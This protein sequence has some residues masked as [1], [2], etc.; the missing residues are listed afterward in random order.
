MSTRRRFAAIALAE[1]VAAGTAPRAL[2]AKV[3]QM[4]G[5]K[6]YDIDL[7]D[8]EPLVVYIETQDI[9]PIAQYARVR[10]FLQTADRGW[11]QLTRCDDRM[12]PCE[13][14]SM[15]I[16]QEIAPQGKQL[17]LDLPEAP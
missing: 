6:P 16:E 12:I 10:V 1:I 11:T 4:F 8:D 7:P 14:S 17:Y 2:A 5:A 13:P 15:Q 9:T 3:T